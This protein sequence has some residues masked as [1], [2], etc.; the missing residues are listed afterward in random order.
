[1][2]DSDMSGGRATTTARFPV[3]A[4]LISE[5]EVPAVSRSVHHPSGFTALL[6]NTF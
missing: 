2:I 5:H 4:A 3:T 6:I 1:V